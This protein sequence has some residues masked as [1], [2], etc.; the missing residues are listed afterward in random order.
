VTGS[1]NGR[2]RR[3]AGGVRSVRG[4]AAGGR[5]RL[6]VVPPILVR[7]LRDGFEESVHR[8]DIVEVDTDGRVIR[9]IGDPNRPV[10]LRAAAHPFGV[11][12][13][14][15]AGGL[16]AFALEPSEIALMAGSHSG[17]DLHV[18]TLQ[19][20]LRRATL[21]QALLAC[22][23]EGM[24]LDPLTAARLAR[25]GEKAG[26]VRHTC[27]G[28]HAVA[29]L[30]SKLNGWEITGYWQ[31]TH[32]VQVA[33]ATALARAFGTTPDRL[34]RATDACGL[35]TWGVPLHEVARAYAL[36]AQP[37]AIPPHDPRSGLAPA[38]SLIRDSMLAHPEMVGGSRDR[39]D[40][41]L[42][43]TVPGRLVSK[44]G[45]E[46]LRGVAI[47]PGHRN[48]VGPG[49]SG[50]AI[51][52]EDGGADRRASWASTVEALRQVGVLDEHAV[53]ALGRYHRPS[54]RDDEGRVASEAVP[55]FEL[56][57]VGELVR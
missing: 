25:D 53:R 38:L 42:V 5:S 9:A 29:I 23:S 41:S 7:Q 55:G 57:P 31:P 35:P 11:V 15:E 52:I 14:I 3:P 47:L 54:A 26:P 19:G 22:G 30:L 50:L 28:P 46:G 1:P 6:R 2:A 10:L 56:V 33:I 51:K 21:T 36:L 39:L 24:P 48:G 40:T 4:Q 18:R 43:K 12:A 32:P 34:H 13:L 37:S 44:S 45:Q 8:G 17:E 16:D 27:S 20:V 49:A